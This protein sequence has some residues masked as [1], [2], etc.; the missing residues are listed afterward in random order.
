MEQWADARVI[1]VL[2]EMFPSFER[3]SLERALRAMLGLMRVLG[4]AAAARF[5]LQYPAETHEKIA[6]SIE[7]MLTS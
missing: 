6:A 7:T 4:E 1:A 3:G 2:P 5:G